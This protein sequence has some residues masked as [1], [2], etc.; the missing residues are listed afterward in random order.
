M[1]RYFT[2][3]VL[4]QIAIAAFVTLNPLS[5]PLENMLLTGFII[6][7]LSTVATLWFNTITKHQIDK[8]IAAHREQFATEREEIKLSAEREQKKLL[9]KTHK[10][11]EAERRKQRNRAN[12]KIGGTIAIAGG[13]GVIMLMSQFF[14]LG[15]LSLTTAGGAVGGYL[16]RSR[17]DQLAGPEYKMLENVEVIDTD[18]ADQDTQATVDTKG[19]KAEPN[20][21]DDYSAQNGKSV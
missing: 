15:L 6:V 16:A 20:P 8:H 17:R 21:S 13:F 14:T 11:I 10:E 2:G 12:L 5:N 19:N 4:V 7:L 3:L 9:K 1:L 18:S